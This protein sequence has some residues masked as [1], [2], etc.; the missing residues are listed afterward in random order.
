M[1]INVYKRTI[2][3]NFNKDHLA[4]IELW[5]PFAKEV[6]VSFDNKTFALNKADR[7]YWELT[8]AK[9]KPGMRYGFAIDGKAPLPDPASLFQP[10]SVHGQSAA[11]PLHNFKWTDQSWRNP[12]LGNYII[13]ELHT[14]TFTPEG[15]FTAIEEKLDY[16]VE[17]GVIAIE[18]M[19]VAQFAG[20]RN[21]GYDGVFPF[22]VQNSYG[23]PD[24]LQKLVDACHAKGLAVI[25]DV[26][27]NHMGPEGN[28][29]GQY[30][31]YFTEKYNTP[32]GGAI[33]FDDAWCDGVRKYFIENVLMWFRDFHIDA[34]RMDAVHAI[35]D[36][37]PKHILQEMKEYVEQLKQVT[38]REHYLIIECDLNDTRYIKTTA[39]GGF[40]MDAQWTDEFHHALRVAAGQKRDGYYADFNG[41]EDMAKAYADAYVYDGQYSEERHKTFGV[42]ATGLDGKQFVVFSQ[43]HDH[44]GNRMLGERTSTLLSFE[45]QKLLVAAVM[46]SPYLPLLFMGEEYGEPNPFQYFVSHTDPELVEAVRKGRRE[47]FKNFQSEGEAPDPQAID[48]FERSKLQWELLKE[49]HHQV[50]FS[51][52]KALI[53]LRKTHAVLKTTTRD[54][55]QTTLKAEQ[56]VLIVKRWTAEQEVVC[57]LNFSEQR[58]SV[59]VS[60]NWTKIFD[61][62]STQWGGPA[63]APQVVNSNSITLQPQS[64]T[65]YAQ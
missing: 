41:L 1:E 34:L 55:L 65:I 30:G 35:K 8:T 37:S 54:T 4:R 26:V 19:P 58:Q 38:G 6:E 10:D 11:T 42:K 23:G 60:G 28:Y 43:N 46:V 31:P 21:W 29:L 61:S 24:G 39:E 17:L 27:Y 64:A 52:Y 2:G 25:L 3:V 18:I 45:M 5:A 16:L 9:L 20:E 57:L 40:G 47:E 59:D 12:D 56:H 7:G 44:I 22:A 53:H 48:T 49:Q 13:Y 32:W 33:N 36:F 63:D 50:L 15:N 51:Y 14:G 62:A